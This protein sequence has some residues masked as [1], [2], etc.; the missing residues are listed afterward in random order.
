MDIYKEDG[1]T[2]DA[3][4][5]CFL[6]WE[7]RADSQVVTKLTEI[8]R[9]SID[10]KAIFDGIEF[11]IPQLAHMSIH[12]TEAT[13]LA[14]LDR[15]N[16]IICLTSPHLALQL[17]FIYIAAL[18]DFQL[19]NARGQKS[20]NGNER[21]YQRCSQLL[22]ETERTFIYG[23][24]QPPASEGVVEGSTAAANENANADVC[25]ALACEEDALKPVNCLLE[26]ALLYK[27][28]ERKNVFRSKGWKTRHFRIVNRS[29]LCYQDDKYTNL[30]RALPLEECTIHMK[31]TLDD[32]VLKNTPIS[33]F[34]DAPKY[35][36]YFEISNNKMGEVEQKF[37]LRAESADDF[38][39]WTDALLCE[40]VIP[41]TNA[42]NYYNRRSSVI[43]RKVD[44]TADEAQILTP[45]QE[46]RYQFFRNQKL[47]IRSLTDIC[48][49]LR[50]VDRAQRKPM[51][52]EALCRLTVPPFC[53]IPLC[54]STDTWK[55][56]LQTSPDE[57]HAFTTKARVPAL[58]IFEVEEHP[59]K[60]D[61]AT[62]LS[63]ELNDYVA[64]ADNS[65]ANENTGVEAEAPAAVTIT[66]ARPVSTRRHSLMRAVTP[67]HSDQSLST[68][69]VGG[70][71]DVIS[72]TCRSD[73][74]RLSVFKM[75][76]VAEAMAEAVAAAERPESPVEVGEGQGAGGGESFKGKAAR[77]RATSTVGHLENWQLDG[78]IA[79]SNDDVRQEVFIMQLISYYAGLFKDH[80]VPVWL[81]PYRIMNA[82][83]T[84]GLIQLVPDSISI[85]GLKKLDSYE[86]SMKSHFQMIYNYKSDVPVA[87]GQHSHQKYYPENTSLEY[88]VAVDNY[89]RSMAGYS[90]VTYL[91]AI[92][93]RHNGNIM[94]DAAGHIIHIDFG[95]VFGLAPGMFACFGG[96]FVSD[97]Y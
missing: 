4:K 10:E 12:L 68:Q 48:D 31:S 40:S 19:E 79:K 33:Q 27:R 46:K 7:K 86:G 29:L 84:T 83:K 53:Y 77:V 24:T 20:A 57:C 22:Q 66:A 61:V 16:V 55:Y 26:G 39:K 87:T 63:M 73:S 42:P 54:K 71:Q 35:E 34:A 65:S 64:E 28:I 13:V 50:Y 82:S 76:S 75:D 78:V 43:Y 44:P 70:D 92:K 91:L 17:S 72:P 14:A 38:A 5:I 2:L 94:V 60:L 49:A 56:I 80:K 32:E 41:T 3:K 96:L 97:I 6:I 69:S 51:L 58:M 89:I 52:K 36:H 62:F 95:F 11:F 74:R 37:L 18:E 67:D 47:F 21:L 85:D 90:I 15:L 25:G 30:L 93:D 9:K 81:H 88:I 23:G 8:L 59:N 45:R 1:K